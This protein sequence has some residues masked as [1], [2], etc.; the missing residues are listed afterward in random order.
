MHN[1]SFF[2]DNRTFLCPCMPLL[3]W[4][5]V[6]GHP[7]HHPSW[8]D[9]ASGSLLQVYGWLSKS[10]LKHLWYQQ[11]KNRDNGVWIGTRR[12]THSPSFQKDSGRTAHS[13]GTPD[14][15]CQPCLGWGW[16]HSA[17]T[18]RNR[19]AV[20]YSCGSPLTSMFGI[21]NVSQWGANYQWQ[22]FPCRNNLRDEDLKSPR[23]WRQLC[24]ATLQ[25][26]MW[27][28]Y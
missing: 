7:L 23:M 3:V 16:G 13:A 17:E 2:R 18:C 25:R 21:G 26:L 19:Y 9:G 11:A 10:G 27:K 1:L 4:V 14:A 15:H 6:P 22:T 28:T 12:V 8:T 5:W 20:C 24:A